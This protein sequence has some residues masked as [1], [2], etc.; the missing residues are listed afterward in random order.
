MYWWTAILNIKNDLSDMMSIYPIVCIQLPFVQFSVLCYKFVFDQKQ[1]VRA[2]IIILGVT[3]KAVAFESQP[4]INGLAE[5]LRI[6][7][8]I[9]LL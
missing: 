6:F 8:V 2:F 9:N 5:K 7:F 4:E 3:M 1:N